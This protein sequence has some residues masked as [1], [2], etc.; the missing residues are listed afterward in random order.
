MAFDKGWRTIAWVILGIGGLILAGGLLLAMGNLRHVLY[1][2]RADGVVVDIVREGNMYAPVVRFR[3]PS[4]E[5][6]EVTDLGSGAPDFSRGDLVTV[7]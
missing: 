1:G 2:D 6:Q 5:L 7:L 3:L 4:G